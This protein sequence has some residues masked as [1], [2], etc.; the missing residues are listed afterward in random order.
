MK[1]NQQYYGGKETLF[2]A[3]REKLR[4]GQ[5]ARKEKKT[6]NRLHKLHID[7]KH[8]CMRRQYHTLIFTRSAST[9]WAEIR[10]NWIEYWSQ[11][12]SAIIRT[13]IKFICLWVTFELMGCCR[14]YCCCCFYC[15]S[16]KFSPRKTP[17][18]T[19][20]AKSFVAACVF[21]KKQQEEMSVREGDLSNERHCCV[22]CIHEWL[23]NSLLFIRYSFFIHFVHPSGIVD[24]FDG[25]DSFV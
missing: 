16:V 3:M 22:R 11:K 19:T 14:C 25:L 8:V 9:G 10:L 7:F 2:Y 5:M 17:R 6:K 20:N 15:G 4:K 13:H 18:Q 21:L 12:F 24:L 23:L 1:K